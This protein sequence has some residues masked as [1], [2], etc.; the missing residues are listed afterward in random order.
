MIASV[1][2]A[3]GQDVAGASTVMGTSHRKPQ[4]KDLVGSVRA[5]LGELFGLPDGWEIVLGNGG[6]TVFWDAAVF[7]LIDQKSQHLTFGEFSSKFAECATR[8]PFVQD[9]T[10]IPKTVHQVCLPST[11]QSGW[12]VSSP[13]SSCGVSS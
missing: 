4:V 9:P 8:A 1:R 7:G 13:T 10:V 5:G 3:A 2:R 12:D 11:G 6:T